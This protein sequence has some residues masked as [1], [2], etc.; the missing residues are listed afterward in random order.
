MGSEVYIDPECINDNG[1]DYVYNRL[2]IYAKIHNIDDIDEVN[3]WYSVFS[4]FVA[5]EMNNRI[6]TGDY[7]HINIEESIS[8][9]EDILSRKY[10]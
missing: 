2:L 9:M 8:T 1:E 10:G 7:N 4:S 5:E 3:H 6:E